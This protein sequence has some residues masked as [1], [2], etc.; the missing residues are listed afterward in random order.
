[1]PTSSSV[2]TAPVKKVTCRSRSPV[3]ADAVMKPRASR[4]LSAPKSRTASQQCAAGALT[5]ASRMIDALLVLLF[6][7]V[8]S[9]ARAL[10]SVL[11]VA[12]VQPPRERVV[13]D[14]DAPCAARTPRSPARAPDQAWV[15]LLPRSSPGHDDLPRSLDQ[16]RKVQ[17]W[18][19]PVNQS[20]SSGISRKLAVHGRM[21]SQKLLLLRIRPDT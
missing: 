18:P 13:H 20:A 19:A 4:S 1:M 17:R 10:C 5:T 11:L 12:L 3:V 9:A 8:G 16:R 21:S 14:D 6:L 2:A 7:S 15:S